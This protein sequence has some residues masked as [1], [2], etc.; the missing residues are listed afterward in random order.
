MHWQNLLKPKPGLLDSMLQ[1][2]YRASLRL[3]LD[4]QAGGWRGL[5]AIL[6]HSGDSWFWMIGLGLVG[7][8]GTPTWRAHAMLLA[9]GVGGLALV[10]FA[11]KH[12]FHRPRP[13]GKWG[14]IYRNTDPHSFPSGHAARMAMLAVMAIGLGPAWFA[15]LLVV[16]APAV[17][18]ARVMMGV[19]YLSDVL[20]G[21]AFGILAGVVMLVAQPLLV[22]WFHFL[23]YL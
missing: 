1:A 14:A 2:D 13:Q 5:A 22:S 10:V 19:H 18:L 9:I 11:I 3:R 7:L 12:L 20:A 23:F 4:G 15:L 8:L 17:S 21:C 6:A 16:W